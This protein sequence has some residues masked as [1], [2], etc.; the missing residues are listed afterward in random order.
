MINNFLEYLKLNYD[1]SYNDFLTNFIHENPSIGFSHYYGD[2]R[3]IQDWEISEIEYKYVSIDS[4]GAEKIEFDLVV[5][6]T[7]DVEKYNKKLREGEQ[8]QLHSWFI[9]VCTAVIGE[10]HLEKLA[11]KEIK[12]YSKEHKRRPLDDCLVP[13]IERKEYEKYAREI[14]KKYYPSAFTDPKNFDISRL[15]EKMGLTW[16]DAI[17]SE[18]RH[19]LGKLIFEE[20]ELDV[21][22]EEFDFSLTPKKEVIPANTILIDKDAA[23]NLGPGAIYITLAHECVHAYLHRKAV[24]FAKM[25][26]SD[27]ELTD[28]V[29]WSDYD[30]KTK[31]MEAQANGI[32]PFLALPKE[33]YEKEY[34]KTLLRYLKFAGNDEYKRLD[35][36][37]AAI[38]DIASDYYVTK[39]SV[40]TRLI[41]DGYTDALGCLIYLDKGY[42]PP[43]K[44]KVGSLAEDETYCISSNK[45]SDLMNDPVFLKKMMTGNYLFLENHLVINDK[46]YVISENNKLRISDYGRLH[47]NECCLKFKLISKTKKPID[48]FT[49]YSLNRN[50]NDLGYDLK[51]VTDRKL[52]TAP[53]ASEKMMAFLDRKEEVIDAIRKMNFADSLKYIMDYWEISIAELERATNLSERTIN[54]YRSGETM[55]DQNSFVALSIGLK[56]SPE[57]VEILRSK[58]RVTFVSNERKDNFMI[59]AMTSLYGR[60]PEEVNQAFINAG[61]GPLTRSQE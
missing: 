32:A 8:I 3:D 29:N 14:L 47:L 33:V 25:L 36:V 34:N 56:I 48:E 2:V 18:D 13:V 31:R 1:E 50:Q 45:I 39:M 6:V 61:Y 51:I 26:D 16:R 22:E 54:R 20:T 9:V 21:W 23:L 11:V 42:I 49:T 57:L 38:E 30:N 12:E 52:Q 53:D 15:P 46:K 28:F 27:Y 60:S 10:E 7:L 35:A 37:R 58:T 17:L 5:S 4:K 40:K 43:F 55:P 44:Y 59:L 24:R 41:A 19:V